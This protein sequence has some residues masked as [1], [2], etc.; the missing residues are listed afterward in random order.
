MEVYVREGRWRQA[1]ALAAEQGRAHVAACAVRYC[2]ASLATCSGLKAG[3]G[4]ECNYCM[5]L[6][7]ARS[8][9]AGA[10]TAVV[11]MSTRR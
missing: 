3:K 5:L 7:A 8:A 1:H 6:C 2:C 11:H 4:L 9:A 10:C